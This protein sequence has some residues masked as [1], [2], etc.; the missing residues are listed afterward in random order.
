MQ[1]GTNTP[2][3]RR[4]RTRA[5]A[6][7]RRAAARSTPASRPHPAFTATVGRSR[8]T[9]NRQQCLQEGLQA[10]AHCALSLA[11]H[12]IALQQAIV[13]LLFPLPLATTPPICRFVHLQLV[14]ACSTPLQGSCE[15]RPSASVDGRSRPLKVAR[16]ATGRRRAHTRLVARIRTRH[17]QSFTKSQ[18]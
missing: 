7:W 17:S 16:A 5:T 6:S 1:I 3:G 13:P 4:R 15:L 10:Q 14:L 11:R 18:L 12:L 2:S 9:S 8:L